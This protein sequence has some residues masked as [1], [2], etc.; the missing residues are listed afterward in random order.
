MHNRRFYQL[1]AGEV[2][3]WRIALDRSPMNLPAAQRLLSEDERARASGLRCYEHRNRWVVG[4]ATLRLILGR[5][6]GIAP[7]QLYFSCSGNEKPDLSEQLGED[8]PNFNISRSGEFALCAIARDRRVG[9]DIERVQDDVPC[10]DIARQRF[11][12]EEVT[13]LKSLRLG[14]QRSAFFQLW[15]YKEAYVKALGVGFGTPFDQFAVALISRECAAVVRAVTDSSPNRW[16]LRELVLPQG[17]C[18]AL[19]VEGSNAKPLSFL[20]IC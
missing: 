13:M 20:G 1:D 12:D 9:V 6:V 15:T 16:S 4:R 8:A 14:D 17:Y 7:E 19:A 18:G 3:V 5:Y 2:H 10:L 11:A